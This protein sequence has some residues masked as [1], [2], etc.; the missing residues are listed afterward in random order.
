[1]TNQNFDLQAALEKLHEED[2]LHPDQ[3]A[4]QDK[5]TVQEV[6]TE[7]NYR[8][9]NYWLA[10]FSHLLMNQY[11]QSS[12]ACA[13]ILHQTSHKNITRAVARYPESDFATLTDVQES[14]TAYARQQGV[15]TDG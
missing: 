2:W 6:E 10:Q 13:R 5:M 14:L 3:S 1:M 12:H 11:Q 8:Q 15:K 9:K 7:K 4:F